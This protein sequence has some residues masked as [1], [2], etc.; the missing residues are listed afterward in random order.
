MVPRYISLLRYI[1]LLECQDGSMHRGFYKI[2][3]PLVIKIRFP[4]T[5]RQRRIKQQKKSIPRVTAVVAR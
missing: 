4:F 2:I 1:A 5:C 3:N